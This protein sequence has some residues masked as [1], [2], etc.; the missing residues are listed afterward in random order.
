MSRHHLLCRNGTYYYRRRVPDQLK[1]GN[2]KAELIYS[3][4]TSNLA[5]AKKRRNLED[6]RWDAEL[7]AA[8]AAPSSVPGGPAASPGSA[9]VEAVRAYIA[10]LGARRRD[11]LVNNPPTSEE[12][13]AEILENVGTDINIL[14]NLDDPRAGEWIELTESR[15]FGAAATEAMRSDARL[16]DIVRREL[17]EHERRTLN[18]LQDGKYPHVYSN[19]SFDPKPPQPSFEAVAKEFLSISS[20]RAQANNTSQK[21]IDKQA[22]HIALLTEI[23]GATTPITQVNYNACMRVVSL[24]AQIPARRNKRY[25]GLSVEMAG[26]RAKADGAS[27]LTATTQNGY[28]ASL[29][30]ILDL[31][32]KKGLIPVNPADGLKA[33]RKETLS[34]AQKRL[35]FNDNQLRAF[36]KGGFYRKCAQHAP[37]W[38]ADKKGWRFWLPLLC[39]YMGMRP[40]EACQ[41]E[42]PDLCR[43]PAGNWYLDITASEDEDEDG[44]AK[45]VKTFSSRRRICLHPELI[46]IGFIAFVKKRGGDGKKRLFP[47][48]TPDEYGNC[49]KYALKRF[50]EK[51]LP[52]EI[53]LEERQSFYSFRHSYRDALRRVGAPPETLQAQGG[54]SQGKIVSDSYGDAGNPDFHAKWV[55]AVDFPGLDLS[56]LHGEVAVMG[57]SKSAKD[58]T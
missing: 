25:P 2:A 28:L 9:E 32:L 41:L 18:W 15:V 22:A 45:T 19:P 8:Q 42:T 21:W 30:G 46:A 40:N 33:L 6:V 39:A 29:D 55:A 57:N 48:L 50:R 34:P 52:E 23:L 54:W 47:D 36:F 37:A 17:L 5:E 16:R 3:L 4:K 35:P 26:E 14:E 51:F 58:V 20:E 13:R 44:F 10:N 11:S 49:A 31:A 24:L 1:S 53:E 12:E 56:F 27:G 7:K 43:T 38:A